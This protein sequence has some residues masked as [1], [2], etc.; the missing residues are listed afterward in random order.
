LNQNYEKIIIIFLISKYFYS[1]GIKVILIS[2][3][4]KSSICSNLT[5]DSNFETGILVMLKY[6]KELITCFVCEVKL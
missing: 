4:I 3:F 5:I 2:S 6:D 1:N